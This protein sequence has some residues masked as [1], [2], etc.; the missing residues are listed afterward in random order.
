[1]ASSELK[2]FMLITPC[3]IAIVSKLG[4]NNLCNNNIDRIKDDAFY[5]P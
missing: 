4:N 3:W 5:D 2:P 1:M